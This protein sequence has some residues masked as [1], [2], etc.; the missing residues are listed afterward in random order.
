MTVILLAEL[1]LSFTPFIRNTVSTF[2]SL[3]TP[4]PAFPATKPAPVG[5]V[6]PARPAPAVVIAPIVREIVNIEEQ[7]AGIFW[8][9]GTNNFKVETPDFNFAFDL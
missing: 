3:G 4:V 7:V 9:G 6:V 8:T 2:L 1:F 5:K